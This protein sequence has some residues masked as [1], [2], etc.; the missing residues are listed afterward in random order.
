MVVCVPEPV[1]VELPPPVTGAAV[2]LD[3]A[4]PANRPALATSQA[5]P[6]DLT[7][8]FLNVMSDTF[9]FELCN[10]VKLLQRGR[11]AC[12][13]GAR[14]SPCNSRKVGVGEEIFS[15]YEAG[16]RAAKRSL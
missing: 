8:S 9:A 10:A 6:W 1:P 13:V 4:H 16:A 14:R 7:R 12:L 5:R 2:S 15:D 3:L 11:C